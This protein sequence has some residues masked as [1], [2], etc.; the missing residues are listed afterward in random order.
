VRQ[1]DSLQALALLSS[2]EAISALRVAIP[3]RVAGEQLRRNMDRQE[4]FSGVMRHCAHAHVPRREV[5][6][7]NHVR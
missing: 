5:S 4:C 3:T 2:L 7:D 1:N 6:M